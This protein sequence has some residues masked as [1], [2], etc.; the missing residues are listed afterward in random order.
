[1]S[2][3]LVVLDGTVQHLGLKY[4]DQA[5]PELRWTLQ[6]IDHGADGKNWTSYWPCTASGAMAERLAGELEDGQHIILTSG[7]LCYRKRT[8]KAG[9]VSR[10]EILVWSA[11]VLSGSP[12]DQRTDTGEGDSTSAGAIVE[13]EPTERATATKARRPRVPTHLQREWPPE[14]AN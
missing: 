12:Q 3:T 14:P 11:D 6:Q 9:E 8:T 7:K 10:L 5:R 4:D 1:M 13:P 2:I